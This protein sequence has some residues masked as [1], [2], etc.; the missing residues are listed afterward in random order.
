MFVH[1]CPFVRDVKTK[2]DGK[3]LINDDDDDSLSGSYS[4]KYSIL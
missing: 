2:S 3:V 4:D 1:E